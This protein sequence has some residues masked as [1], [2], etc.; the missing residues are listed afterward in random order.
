[1]TTLTTRRLEPV[2]E[3]AALRTLLRVVVKGCQIC[4]GEHEGTLI[5]QDARRVPVAGPSV[6]SAAWV[7]TPTPACAREAGRLLGRKATDWVIT[8]L[9][10]EQGRV[11]R[12]VEEDGSEAT[13]TWAR[14]KADVE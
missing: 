7:A 11:F 2:S 4:G 12:V 10:V 6:R 8:P 13:T 9:A 5:E 3:W 1:V 14:E